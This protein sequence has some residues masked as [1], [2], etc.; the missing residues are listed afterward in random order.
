MNDAKGLMD[1]R[2]ASD[3]EGRDGEVGGSCRRAM[4][5]I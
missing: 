1:S 2:T 3:P 5:T 4:E